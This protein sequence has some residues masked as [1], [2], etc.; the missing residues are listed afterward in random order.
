[1]K[2]DS[3]RK[4][5]NEFVGLIAKTWYLI[6]LIDDSRKKKK[7]HKKVCHKKKTYNKS[8]SHHE[9]VCFLRLQFER[10]FL[11]PSGNVNDYLSHF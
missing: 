7:K 2:Y 6:D 5:M 9:E 10:Y 11:T 8:L 4:I 3:G 1:M